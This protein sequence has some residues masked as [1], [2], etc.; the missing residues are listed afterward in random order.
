MDAFEFN[1]IA[2]CLLAALLVFFGA[3]TISNFVFDRHALEKAG[4]EIE[5]AEATVSGAEEK[6]TIVQD[7]PI[8]VRLAKADTSRGESVAKKCKA[9]HS[10][11]KGGKNGVGPNLWSIVLRDVGKVSGYSYSQ[12]LI[13]LGGK[14]DYSVL[15]KFLANPKKAVPST[16]MAFKGIAKP[17]Q[18]ADLILYLHGLSDKLSP[19]PV[20]I[21]TKPEKASDLKTGS[22]PKAQETAQSG[23]IKEQ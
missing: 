23:R 3:R 19:L 11:T 12:A 20:A 15:D 18:R 16:K 21:D 10:F 17:E 5:V 7:A 22:T 13:A 4:Y 9:C 6:K 1:K 2:G 14:W 8:A